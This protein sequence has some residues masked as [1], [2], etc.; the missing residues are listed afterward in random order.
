MGEALQKE[1]RTIPAK[2]ALCRVG[3]VAPTQMRVAA[4]CRVSTDSEEQLTSYKAQKQYYTE[5]IES[6]SS[7]TLA[8][9]YAD[10]GISG[11]SLKKREQFNQMIAACR[12]GRIDMIL[13]KSV[14]RFARNTVDCLRVVR[15]L[16]EK[17]VG[18]YFEKENINTLQEQS[19]FLITL[20]SGHAQSESESLSANVRWGLQRRMQAG[21]YI[22]R[23]DKMLGYRKSEDGKPEI[24]PE[25][26]AV[27]LDIFRSY[28]A[29]ESTDAIAQ[30]LDCAQ[31]ATA[32]SGKAW[33]K[34]TIRSILT[35]EK[36]KG[37]VLMQKTYVVD[38]LTKK[39]KR[40]T[41]ELPMYYVKNNHPAVISRELFDMVQEEMA[42]RGN[43]RGIGKTKKKGKHSGKYALTRRLVCQECGA[44]YKRC[45]WARNGVKRVVWRCS[46]RLMHGTKYCK[47]SPTLDEPKLHQALVRAYNQVVQDKDE[48]LLSIRHSLEQA[49]GGHNTADISA[50]RRRREQ[51]SLLREEV[52]NLM[53]GTTENAEYLEENLGKFTA[54]ILSI[55]KEMQEAEQMSAIQESSKAR[56]DNLM[57]VIAAFPNSI[58][59]YDNALTTSIVER[60]EVESVEKLRVC[61]VCGV[62]VWVGI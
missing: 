32:N 2:P 35:N 57:A 52:L 29:G 22:F 13:T 46:T 51:T 50:L 55:D 34:S 21:N 12:R 47:Q 25:E 19:E 14:S 6:N 33:S 27:I 40:N 60:I 42:R 45:T 62:E 7:W 26:A 31:V 41:G 5:K 30:R 59:E 49:L 16:K 37:D 11:T 48:I 43:L 53:C 17:N 8:G 61:F 36:Y 44:P 4:Y 23:Y 1:I 39:T 38:C 18:I 15:M 24:V 58:T 54:E 9:I 10:E 20:F 3:G 56:I 28:L